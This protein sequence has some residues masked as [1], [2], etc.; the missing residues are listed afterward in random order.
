MLGVRSQIGSGSRNI[1]LNGCHIYDCG[2]NGIL[3]G[4]TRE[5]GNASQVRHITVT[6]SLI[7][8]VG[9][10]YP[11]SVGIWQGLAAE[12]HITHNTV[13]NMPYS[14]IS[15]G[16]I[17]NDSPSMA[18]NNLISGNHVY[19]V[20]LMLGDGGG[21]YTLGH[22]PGSVIKKNYIHDI[23]RSELN[24]RAPNNGIYPDQGSSGILITENILHDI[25]A[26]PI[27][28]HAKNGMNVDIMAN[29]L[30]PTG[31]NSA[32]MMSPPTTKESISA[33]RTKIS[34]KKYGGLIITSS[35]Q[36]NGVNNSQHSWTK[37][38]MALASLE[39]STRP[40]KERAR[41]TKHKSSIPV[42]SQVFSI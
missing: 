25:A 4:T 16:W 33:K 41:S 40:L 14:G 35:V 31:D 36:R 28:C 13:R 37:T 7:E 27:R 32:G 15:M 20:M 18:Q 10:T 19:N 8:Q 21:I 17:W 29:T 11:G 23:K 6:N 42:A 12:S 3:I 9:Y 30:V 1:L 5:D 39:N 26:S 2:G 34:R 38:S 22:Q 24:S